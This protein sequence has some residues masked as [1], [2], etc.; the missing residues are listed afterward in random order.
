MAN[1]VEL[2]FNPLSN[3]IMTV[4]TGVTVI[5]WIFNLIFG[6]V[7]GDGDLDADGIDTDV[8]VDTDADLDHGGDSSTWDKLLSFVNVGKVPFM[9]VLSVFKLIAWI[10]TLASSIVLNL[11]TWGWMSV[12]I[13]LPVI[14]VAFII[15]RFATKPL[16]K[17]YHAMGYNGE[18]AQD[19]LGRNARM[20]SSISGDTIGFA[21]LKVQGDVMRINVKSKTGEA[22]RFDADVMIM[23]ES[24]DKKYY[25]VVPEVNLANIV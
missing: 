16:I 9:I 5:Y 8:D 3:A 6:S 7:L 13:L 2:L 25:I 21:E 23:D 22:I 11:V 4:T 1:I 24:P 20:L 10:I 17:L 18:E 19:L 14:F 15:T 12:F